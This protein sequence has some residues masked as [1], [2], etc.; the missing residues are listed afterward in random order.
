MRRF[1]VVVV[2]VAG[3]LAGAALG[4]CGGSDSTAD[5]SPSPSPTPSPTGLVMPAAAKEHTKAGAVAFV[6]H[7]VQALNAAMSTGETAAVQRLAAPSCRSCANVVGQIRDIYTHGGHSK[8][9]RWKV[10]RATAAERQPP[11]TAL[12][13]ALVQFEPQ[14]LFRTGDARP[15]RYPGGKQ[16]FNFRLRF[17]DGWAVERSTTAS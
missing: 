16:L 7:Y 8:G 9:G 14:V 12:V 4:G 13:Y 6:K 11:Q 17:N 1:T 2:M 15:R 10:L 3:L 5:P